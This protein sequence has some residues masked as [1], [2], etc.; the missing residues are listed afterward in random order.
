MSSLNFRP[1]QI[2]LFTAQ[3]L[4]SE[5]IVDEYTQGSTNLQS[6]MKQKMYLALCMK[7]GIKYGHFRVKFYRSNP[8]ILVRVQ[9]YNMEKVGN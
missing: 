7:Y 4:V 9:Q 2:Q 5:V 6:F 8:P 1:Q 3:F